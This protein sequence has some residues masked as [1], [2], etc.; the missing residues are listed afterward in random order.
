LQTT[1]VTRDANIINK[2]TKNRTEYRIHLADDLTLYN[3]HRF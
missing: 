2:T 3:I 1:G